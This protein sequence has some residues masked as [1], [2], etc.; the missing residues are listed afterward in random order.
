MQRHKS[1]CSGC[2]ESSTI[3]D[4]SHSAMGHVATRQLYHSFQGGFFPA[5]QGP[6]SAHAQ[7]D[8][9]LKSGT[10]PRRGKKRAITHECDARKLSLR[11]L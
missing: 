10:P 8:P 4:G 3:F 9:W 1:T 11:V 5:Y 6:R 7:L 2:T